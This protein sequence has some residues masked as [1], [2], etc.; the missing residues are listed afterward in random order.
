ML[1]VCASYTPGSRRLNSN[2]LMLKATLMSSDAPP[3]GDTESTMVPRRTSMSWMKRVGPELGG[4][5]CL[6]VVSSLAT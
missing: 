5:L 2:S 3:E 6:Q 1:V 4:A